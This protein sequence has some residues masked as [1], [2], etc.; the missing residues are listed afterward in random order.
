VFEALTAPDR[1]YRDPLTVSEAI[2]ELR[3]LVKGGHLD[4]DLFDVFLRERVHLLYA[5][6]QLRPEQLDDATLDALAQL[7]GGPLPPA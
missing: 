3:R 4:G 7:P 2:D 5:R 6:E 1:P